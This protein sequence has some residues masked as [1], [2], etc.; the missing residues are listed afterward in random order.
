MPKYSGLK[1]KIIEESKDNSK[2]EMY[3]K[4]DYYK[5]MYSDLNENTFRRYVREAFP[6]EI[7]ADVKVEVVSR[8]EMKSQAEID[9]ITTIYKN[10]VVGI[11]GDTHFPYSR[12]GYLEFCRDKF[13]EQ[14]VTCICQIGDLI[15]NHCW[16]RFDSDPYS[17]DGITEYEK[18]YE[19]VQVFKEIFKDFDKKFIVLGNHDRIPVRQLTTLGLPSFLMKSFKELFGLDDWEICT[20]KTIDGTEYRHGEKCTATLLTAQRMRKN[21]VC[22]HSHSKAD[23]QTHAN[24]DSLIWGMH[25]GCGVDDKKLAFSYAKDE[26]HKSVIS[27]AT[28]HYG[29][30]PQ[31]HFMNLD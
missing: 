27:C 12:K 19:D 4:F 29:I 18:A 11:I 17:I 15:D 13:L 6:K 28:V 31:L 24:W 30:S 23:I 14:G 25:V 26:V 2:T 3:E 21:L 20:S 8:E 5:S 10:E 9:I 22:G 7:V 1:K 16:S